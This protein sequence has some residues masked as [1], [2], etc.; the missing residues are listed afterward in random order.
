MKGHGEVRAALVDLTRD[1]SAPEFAGLGH[2][3][4]V[5]AASVPKLAAMLAACQLRHDLRA[6]LSLKKSKDLEDL[7][8]NVRDDCAGT[9]QETKGSALPFT[10]DI[11]VR[12][13]LVLLRGRK[14]D[15][16]TDDRSP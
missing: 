10:K 5:F 2:Q 4:Q 3:E 9:Q 6:A 14:A 1:R 16:D 12:G 8:S 11:A 15:L 13:R 7:F